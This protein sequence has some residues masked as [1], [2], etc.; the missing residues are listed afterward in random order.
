M[1]DF[2]ILSN[3]KFSVA[4][5]ELGAYRFSELAFLIKNLPYQ[6]NKDKDN[7][8]CVIA[9]SGGT[10]STKHAF[11][12]HI[13]IENKE[14]DFRLFLGIFR[15]NAINTP[16][17]KGILDKYQL[18]EI[19]EAHTYIKYKDLIL[20]FTTSQSSEADFVLDLVQEIE[21][22]PTQI[23]SFK[24]NYHQDFLRNYLANQN[25]ISYNSTDFWRIREECIAALQN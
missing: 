9:E 16:K 17:I 21:I 11:L 2:E 7:P 3:Q 8:L 22:E 12:Q 15:M 19:P 24:I 18:N 5:K 10:C 6:R 25:Q 1:K 4:A 14:F 20:D 23:S 13:A